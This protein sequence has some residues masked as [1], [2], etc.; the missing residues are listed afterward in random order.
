MHILAENFRSGAQRTFSTPVLQYSFFNQTAPF[1]V[2]EKATRNV[3]ISA[4]C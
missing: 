1:W 4:F 2:G 3:L